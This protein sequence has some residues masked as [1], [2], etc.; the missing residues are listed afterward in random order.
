MILAKNR[1]IDQQNTTES[2][3]INPHT[4]GQSMTNESR[5]Y[6]GEKTF[7]STSG[8]GKTDQLYVKIKLKHSLTPHTK[9]NSTWIKHINVKTGNHKNPRR[10]HRQNTLT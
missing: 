8:A 6:N 9:M 2:P 1:H 5:I 3:E 4:Y 10:N 7:S